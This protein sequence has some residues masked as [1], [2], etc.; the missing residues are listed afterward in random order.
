MIVV[1]SGNARKTLSDIIN[2]AKYTKERTI[3]TTNGKQVAAVVSMDD[4]NI[5]V[6]IFEQIENESDLIAAKKGLEDY[7]KNGGV[8]WDDA[9]KQLGY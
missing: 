3:I 8:S 4:L 6:N 9:M 2:R 1:S 5:L 7:E